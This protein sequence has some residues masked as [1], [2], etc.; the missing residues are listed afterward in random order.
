MTGL[1]LHWP[2]PPKSIICLAAESFLNCTLPST[3]LKTHR[4]LPTACRIPKALSLAFPASH[5]LN[6]AVAGSPNSPSSFLPLSSPLTLMTW[7]LGTLYLCS[8]QMLFLQPGIPSDS[9]AQDR[10]WR[11]CRGSG[12]GPDQ[13]PFCVYLGSG[14]KARSLGWAALGTLS[15]VRTGH[16]SEAPVSQMGDIMTAWRGHGCPAPSSGLSGLLGHADSGV[17]SALESSRL[18]FKSQYPSYSVTGT[19]HT[20]VNRSLFQ[21]R[22]MFT[23]YCD[24]GTII[25]RYE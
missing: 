17:Q 20:E 13:T 1:S 3:L 14:V 15:K 16:P 24:K 5:H 19:K 22:Q 23:I 6:L 9:R 10:W 2:L 4:W 7:S 18:E 21:M 11:L 8:L 12:G 25:C